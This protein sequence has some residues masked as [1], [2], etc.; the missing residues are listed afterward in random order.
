MK[1][2]TIQTITFVLTFALVFAAPT[3]VAQQN[4]QPAATASQPAAQTS[5]CG[6]NPLCFESTDFVATISQFRTSTNGQWRLLDAIVHFQNK[7][8][9][10]LSLG[11]VNGSATAL[12]DRGNRY[13]LAGINGLRGMGVLYGANIDTRLTLRP[14]G[15]SDAAFE[16][17]WA[18]GNAV[19]GV[20]Y[21][22]DLDIREMNPVEGNQWVLGGD[23][24]MHYQGLANGMGAAPVASGS[25]YMSSA[26][27]GSSMVPGAVPLATSASQGGCPPGTAPANSAGGQNANAQSA[28][29]DAQSAISNLKSL[30]GKKNSTAPTT[31]T[32]SGAPCVPV[33]GVAGNSANTSPQT[34][35]AATPQSSGA[36]PAT[37]TPA[38]ASKTAVAPAA[39]KATTTQPKPAGVTNASS[40]KKLPA[41]QSKTT[42]AT[43]KPAVKT[44]TTT[45]S[46]NSTQQ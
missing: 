33:N 45:P 13:G 21:S 18:P 40:V 25:S 41:A 38:A 37:A 28:V 20:N 23:T 43:T 32:A 4:Q 29:A 10:P 26:T 12:D 1:N 7:T 27:S 34:T 35:S 17:A 14:G 15:A 6:N 30:F 44:S 22:L 36:A 24:F 16:L 39:A 5:L 11:Y 9:Q 8:N 3:V 19:V 2:L 31:N 42:Q 46:T